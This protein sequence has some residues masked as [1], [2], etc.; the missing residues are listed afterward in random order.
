MPHHIFIKDNAV[1]KLL[2]D[3]QTSAVDEEDDE[4]RH[5]DQ[6]RSEVR[7]SKLFGFSDHPEIRIEM[8]EEILP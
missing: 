5:D 4:W 6:H 8:D 2:P 7:P 3:F 1:W